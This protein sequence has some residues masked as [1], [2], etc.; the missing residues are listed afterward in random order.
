MKGIR[1]ELP[2]QAVRCK[3]VGLPGSAALLLVLPRPRTRRIAANIAKLPEL[4]AR[5][6][7]RLSHEMRPYRHP[8]GFDWAASPSPDTPGPLRHINLVRQQ[9]P[10]RVSVCL[11]F[12]FFRAMTSDASWQNARKWRMRAVQSRA[13][14][15][16]M[17]DVEAKAI[18]LRIADDYARLAD[19][20]EKNSVSWWDQKRAVN[21]AR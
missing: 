17:I 10:G 11:G 2:S 1:S 16:D 4:L 19:W 21:T 18:M 6:K 20:A 5:P 15:D 7:A 13:F 3:A 12:S 8:V 14:A 9:N